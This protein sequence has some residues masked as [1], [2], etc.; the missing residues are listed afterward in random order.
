ME[1]NVGKNKPNFLSNWLKLETRIKM[2][3]WSWP[4]RLP[5]LMVELLQTDVSIPA[6]GAGWF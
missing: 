3:R 1:I 2:T 6:A 5:F 4:V